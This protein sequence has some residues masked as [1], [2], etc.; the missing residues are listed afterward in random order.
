MYLTQNTQ[1]VTFLHF[2]SRLGLSIKTKIFFITKQD[3]KRQS[4]V[5]MENI[6]YFRIKEAKNI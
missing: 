2:N 5:K 3:K 6:L 1:E 4:H